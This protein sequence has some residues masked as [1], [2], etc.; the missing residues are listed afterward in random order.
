M[1]LGIDLGTSSVKV[2]LIDEEQNLIATSDSSLK[3]SRPRPIWS[4]QNPDDW[5][6][7]TCAA[8]KQIRDT[9]A[10]SLKKVRAIGLSGQMHGATMLDQNDR[11]LRPAILWNDGR[12]AQ[13][14]QTLLSRVPDAP[15]ITGNLI[16]PG[17]TAP[18]VLWVKENEP[19]LF[20]QIRKILLPK[21]Y[22]RLKMTGNYA[23]DLSDA[24][25]TSWLNVQQRK[26]SNI[27]IDATEITENQ[28]PEL[29]EGTEI[30]GKMLPDIANEW[31][32]PA[33]AEV[34]AGGGDN[35]ASAISMGVIQPGQ[36]FLSLG[37]SGVYFIAD[38]QFRPN[39]QETLHTMC[40]CVP[41][42]W[43]E[44]SVHLS[45]ASCLSWIGDILKQPN[46]HQ[47]IELA[48]QH[49]AAHTPIFLPYLS[50][51]RTPHNNP[52]AR[53][54][55]FGLTAETGP[56]ELVQAVLEGVAFAFCDGQRVIANAGVKIQEVNVIGGGAKSHY[57]GE[58]LA[59]ALNRPLTYRSQASIGGA[60][61][62]AR[63]GWYSQHDIEP[64][65]AFS[66]PAIEHIINPVESL[67]LRYE[68]K[69]Q[70][71]NQTYQQLNNLFTQFS[72]DSL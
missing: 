55:F 35:A 8:I 60:F 43:H 32:I 12:A 48:K 45:A 59:S 24:S 51:E 13:Q 10:S 69:Q 2:T 38:N 66:S 70:L 36:A 11:P 52:N 7:A 9:H 15:R 6:Q 29:F 71:F 27:M 46:F 40:H 4:E 34:V 18:K 3:V 41:Q 5:W 31:G 21:D 39:P 68:K 63:L 22:L 44:M 42:L 64:L 56:S 54:T 33:D 28:L 49:R 26:W 19:K 14:C 53:G 30:T 17:F 57:W 37:T 72:E 67:Q 61:G 65:V 20:A 50:G 58:I 16:M 25:G 62:A 47:L 1:Y 23:T